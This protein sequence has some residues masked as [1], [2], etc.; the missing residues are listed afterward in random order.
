MSREEQITSM[1]G[2][3]EWLKDEVKIVKPEVDP[4]LE[5]AAGRTDESEPLGSK[6]SHREVDGG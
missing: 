2:A 4:V 5:V 6:G 3:L 1:R